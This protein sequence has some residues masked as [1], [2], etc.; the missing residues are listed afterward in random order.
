MNWLTCSAG[1]WKSP[2]NSSRAHC[3]GETGVEHWNLLLMPPSPGGGGGSGRAS[4][5]T[6][7]ASRKQLGPYPAHG[8]PLEDTR[9]RKTKVPVPPRWVLWL[10]QLS[11]PAVCAG[12][13]GGSA[14]WY[15]WGRCHPCGCWLVLE[16]W[17]GMV[18]WAS[19]SPVSPPCPSPAVVCDSGDSVSPSRCLQGARSAVNPRSRSRGLAPMPFPALTG[20]H[21]VQGAGNAIQVPEEAVLVEHLGSRSHLVLV[22]C[23]SDIRVHA[24]HGCCG[25]HRL[26]LLPGQ[27]R[28]GQP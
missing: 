22:S 18:P 15:T 28:G 1:S 27:R 5:I 2:S 20:L 11:L 12:W 6:Q 9:G 10:G 19:R 17:S 4:S 13:C 14:A 16:A 24:L 26:G 3:G 7:A 8:S 21:R 23:H 25:H